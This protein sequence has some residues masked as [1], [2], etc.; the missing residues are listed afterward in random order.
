MK[1]AESPKSDGK[2]KSETNLSILSPGDEILNKR[3]AKKEKNQD[4]EKNT[5]EL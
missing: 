4:L 5:A 1:I 2:N 3:L